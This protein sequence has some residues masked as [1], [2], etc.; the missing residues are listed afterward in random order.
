MGACLVSHTARQDHGTCPPLCTGPHCETSVLTLTRSAKRSCDTERSST[1]AISTHS[2]PIGGI[3][4]AMPSGSR[5]LEPKP[6][7]HFVMITI[8]TTRTE[9]DATSWHG[10][11]E[12]S[13]IAATAGNDGLVRCAAA[14]PCP[15]SL[16]IFMSLVNRQK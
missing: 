9:S 5:R 4:S 2:A 6:L 3:C 13:A 7:R 16:H 1:F 15:P 8:G 12:T 10:A 11:A 14:L